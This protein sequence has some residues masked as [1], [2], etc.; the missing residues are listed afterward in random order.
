[1]ASETD[2]NLGFAAGKLAAE[3]AFD[4]DETSDMLFYARRA[5]AVPSEVLNEFKDGWLY[6]SENIGSKNYVRTEEHGKIRIHNW[7]EGRHLI[8]ET[9]A[10]LTVAPGTVDRVNDWLNQEPSMDMDSVVNLALD[11]F[12]HYY[13]LWLGGTM[14][15]DTTEKKVKERFA[16]AVHGQTY[17]DTILEEQGGVHRAETS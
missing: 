12:A 5:A 11:C 1:M 15:G 2:R 3:E 13:D 10:L 8:E 16:K 4:Q 7:L 14:S 17:W 6:A 9:P